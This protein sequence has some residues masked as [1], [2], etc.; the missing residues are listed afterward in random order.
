MRLKSG[1]RLKSDVAEVVFV[2]PKGQLEIRM[3]Q[4]TTTRICEAALVLKASHF[5]AID[6]WYVAEDKPLWGVFEMRTAEKD[7]PVRGEWSVRDPVKQFAAKTSDAA[8]MYAVM[9]AGRA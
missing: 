5:V 7:N 3:M 8:V 4:A 1:M 6:D 9:L 2:T